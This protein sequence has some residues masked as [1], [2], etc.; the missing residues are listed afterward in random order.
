M[1]MFGICGA[2]G[3]L[4]ATSVGGQLFDAW[5]P[6]GPYVLIGFANGVVFV[7]ALLVRMIDR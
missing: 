6:A 4:F 3:I 7:M 1:G 5:M 2:A